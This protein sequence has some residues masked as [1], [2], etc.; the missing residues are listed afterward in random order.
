VPRVE[1]VDFNIQNRMTRSPSTQEIQSF[2]VSTGLS[3]AQLGALI[4]VDKNTWNAYV[5]GRR[6]MPPNNWVMVNARWFT[7]VS[8][9]EIFDLDVMDLT[10]KKASVLAL[11]KGTQ[12]AVAGEIKDTVAKLYAS[13]ELGVDEVTARMEK[14][15]M[16]KQASSVKRPDRS[17]DGFE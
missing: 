10:A 4:N 14:T 15:R 8:G 17:L 3:S 6:T 9:V 11:L 12:S 2:A 7:L 16:K 1:D 13:D 5:L